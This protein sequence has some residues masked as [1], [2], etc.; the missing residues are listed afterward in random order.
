MTDPSG[1]LDA[2]GTGARTAVIDIG[3]N[4]IRLVVYRD[5]ARA[6]LQLFNEKVLC[7]LGRGMA[8]TG[9]LNPDGVALALENL[10]RFRALVQAMGVARLDVVA[11]AAVRDA[12]NGAEFVEQLRHLGIDIRVLSG[13]DEARLSAL[14]VLSG[15]PE[16]DGLMGDLG[17]GSLELVDLDRGHPDG[18]V[19]GAHVTLPLGPLRLMDTAGGNLRRGQAIVDGTLAEI[20]WLDRL[21]GRNFYA[22]GG[23]WRMLARHLMESRRYPLHI[24]HAFAVDA[25]E[26]V[27]F[28]QRYGKLIA[29]QDRRLATLP[30][31]RLETLPWAALVLERLFARA[32]PHSLVFS[33]FGLRE[34][35]LFERLSAVSRRGDPLLTALSQIAAGGRFH[36]SPDEIVR[37]LEPLTGAWPTPLRRLCLAACIA[38]DLAWTEHPDYRAEQAYYR[39]LRLP[40]V[41]IDHPGRAFLALAMAARYGGEATAPLTEVARSLLSEEDRRRATVLG[42]SLRLAYTLT[43]GAPGILS[44]CRLSRLDPTLSLTL[45]KG[46]ALAVGEAVPRR[47]EAIAR[48][49][50]LRA[51]IVQEH[52]VAAA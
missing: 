5:G 24:I 33:A 44:Q 47:L 12:D 32:M 29:K 27:G 9:R 6:P 41:G 19:P 22:V 13:V 20:D 50:S 45:S 17:G 34:G 43:G 28:L 8:V 18:M 16:A 38:S 40:V 52:P 42:L 30:R 48:V 15:I 23:A 36:F 31:K 46:F 2:H 10:A 51:E 49:L 14:G 21:Q 35:V 26:A 11:T 3:S 4:S 1:I 37:F 39:M 7:G 25:V